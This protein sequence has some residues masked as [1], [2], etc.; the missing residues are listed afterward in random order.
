MKIILPALAL[1]ALTAAGRPAATPLAGTPLCFEP[2]S[3]KQGQDGGGPAFIARGPA[4]G[5]LI[6]PA[7]AQ[8][9]LRR[10]GSESHQNRTAP[11]F[12]L[13]DPPPLSANGK[14]AVL[15]MQFIGANPQAHILGENE[16]PA[17]IN[18]LIGNDP[19]RW[20]AGVP[21]FSKVRVAQLYPGVNLTY[22]G[23]G[24][25]LEYDFTL[26][27][28][29]DP[30][31]IRIRFSGADQ[32]FIGRRGELVLKLGG[33]EIRQPPP[34]VYQPAGGGRRAIAG[35]YKLLDAR[36]V[37]VSIGTYDR[38]LPLVIDPIL[39]FST[40]FGGNSADTGWAIAVD[41]NGFIYVAGNTLSTQFSNAPGGFQTNFQGGASSGDAFVAKFDNAGTNLIYLTYLGGSGDDLAS[42]V[43]VDG[44]GRA[45]VTG[46]TD[47]TN[48]PTTTN[49]LS[50][51]I[52]GT[53]IPKLNTYPVDAFVAELDSGGSNLVYSTYLGGAGTDA[54]TGIAVDSSDNAYVTGVTSSTNFPY[55]TNAWQKQLACAGSAFNGNAFVSEIASNGALVYSTYLGGTNFDEGEGIAVDAAGYIYAT[56]FTDSTNFPTTNALMASLDGLTNNFNFAYDAFAAKFAPAGATPVYVTY[57]GGAS[58]DAGYAI[59]ADAG[60]SAYVAGFTDSTNFPD[61][62]TNVPGL[63]SFVATNLQGFRVTNAFLTRISPDGSAMDYSSVFG[64]NVRDV[65]YG[66]AVDPS[67]NA[68]VIGATASTNFPVYNAAG[69]LRA[70]NS[71]GSDVFVTAFNTN[72]S[73]LLYSAY[74]GGAGA[75][76]GY[77][78][79]LDPLDNAYLV[80]QTGSTDFPTR[81]A[82]QGALSGSSDAFLAK[83]LL[84]VPSPMLA[85]APSGTNE[86]VVSWPAYLPYEE[87]LGQLFVL[88]YNPD[89]A[90]PSNWFQTGLSPVLTN[91]FYTYSLNVPNLISYYNLTNLFF[92]LRAQP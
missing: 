75:D 80:G 45:Y 48:F 84:N 64:G 87:E 77:G 25:Q 63:H 10:A 34:V 13:L 85:I 1:A 68:F 91:G 11:R 9:A 5:F 41:T 38:D 81:N 7:R 73:A 40:Y 71:G 44:T 89:L 36:T 55:T 15:Q 56:G 47:S 59:A 21:V 8:L 28:K 4:Y 6:A 49:A 58:D 17:K 51:T 14:V 31:R 22:Y 2:S 88:Q 30:G 16:L 52:H 76:F 20:R 29:A 43:A 90:S 18:Y 3:C 82:R 74:L 12:R 61:T 23:N 66:L 57:L 53:L 92:R 79:A 60:G 67:G 86:E 83:I 26:A 54:G 72:A 33:A 78:I 32:V 27:P 39:S 46:Y 19:V 42:G 62:V 65:A 24:Q 50:K 70:T 35:G 37:T 69:L